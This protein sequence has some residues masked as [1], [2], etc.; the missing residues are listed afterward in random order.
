[1]ADKSHPLWQR[2]SAVVTALKRQFKRTLSATRVPTRQPRAAVHTCRKGGKRLRSLLILLEPVYG[3]EA[4]QAERRLRKAAGKLA[5]F[6]DATARVQTLDRLIAAAPDKVSAKPLRTLRR[7]MVADASYTQAPAAVEAALTDFHSVVHRVQSDVIGWPKVS[8]DRGTVREGLKATYRLTRQ[9]YLAAFES[10]DPEHLHT[11]RKSLQHFRHQMRLLAALQKAAAKK[12][13][14]TPA[15]AALAERVALV[16]ALSDYLGEDHDLHVLAEFLHAGPFEL[17]PALVA[18]VDT[19]MKAEGER[20][21]DAAFAMGATLFWR[22][23]GVFISLMDCV[24]EGGR[25]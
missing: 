18:A 13:A 17:P 8:P 11:W 9:G 5:H 16:D 22:K 14:P 4:L 3:A 21:R 1:M 7:M 15:Q 24:G 10:S 2:P 12:D 25:R 23:P 19:A 6:R 20:L